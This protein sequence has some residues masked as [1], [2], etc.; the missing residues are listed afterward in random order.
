MSISYDRILSNG[1]KRF[2]DSKLSKLRGNVFTTA[3]VDNIDH[4]PSSATSKVSFHGTGMSLLQH[5]S[6]DGEG[7]DRNIALVGESHSS[8]SVDHLPLFYTDAT[9]V[10]EVSKA[11]LYQLPP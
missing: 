4:N 11:Y 8:K 6:V 7:V 10:T 9:P 2:T 5:P 1:V 3:A